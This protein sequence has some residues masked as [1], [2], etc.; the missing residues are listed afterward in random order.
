M[1]PICA[2]TRHEADDEPVCD[3]REL[4]RSGN[5]HGQAIVNSTVTETPDLFKCIV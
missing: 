2:L 1:H 4:K 5:D 3:A